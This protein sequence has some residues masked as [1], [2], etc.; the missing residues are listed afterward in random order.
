[1]SQDNFGF[2]DTVPLNQPPASRS[3]FKTLT[4]P[5]ATVFH[6]FFK[7]LAL[8]VYLFSGTLGGG[9][10]IFTFIIC[11]LALSFDFWTVKN[12][13]GRL[14]VGLRW[15]N[16]TREDGSSEWV[17]ESADES[18]QV[19]QIEALIFWTTL[20]IAPCIWVLCALSSFLRLNAN[21]LV[22]TLVGISLTG[23]NVIGY[24]KCAKDAKGKLN[25][26]AQSYITDTFFRRAGNILP[27]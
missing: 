5:I 18:K 1:M 22:V 27:L 8:V 16:E 20:Y 9:S 23:A 24:Q 21:W 15:W 14:M 25:S 10:F 4:H 26:Y 17:F 2:G 19:N 13:T 11:I 6:I 3:F 7:A 12:I